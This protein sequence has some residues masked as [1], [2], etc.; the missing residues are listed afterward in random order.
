LTQ[1]KKVNAANAFEADLNC[2]NNIQQFIQGLIHNTK[3]LHSGETIG[4]GA[5]TYGY[6][7]EIVHNEIY[8][9]LNGMQRGK[10]KF[11]EV[12]LKGDASAF[13]NV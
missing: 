8:R 10:L 12:K 7:V 6:R 4:A 5:K 11:Q 3:W 1:S 13:E 9:M 2:H